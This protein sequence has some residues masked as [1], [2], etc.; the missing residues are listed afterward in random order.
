[1][2]IGKWLFVQDCIRLELELS[3][4]SLEK[5][6]HWVPFKNIY[7]YFSGSLSSRKGGK[8]ERGSEGARERTLPCTGSPQMPAAAGAGPGSGQDPQTPHGPPPRVQRPTSVIRRLLLPE[9][10]LAKRWI[11][12]RGAI[13]GTKLRSSFQV[14]LCAVLFGGASAVIEARL[15]WC[16]C[17]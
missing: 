11:G 7:F 13:S 3:N 15:F 12:S 16:R 10:K 2:K 9:Y 4:V 6:V 17:E 1:M 8:G 14:S 5:K